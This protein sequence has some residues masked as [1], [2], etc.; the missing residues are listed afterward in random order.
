MLNRMFTQCKSSGSLRLP[1]CRIVWHI[2]QQLLTGSTNPCFRKQL[3]TN[4]ASDSQTSTCNI[5]SICLSQ[6]SLPLT[7]ALPPKL[8]NT[9]T[10]EHRAQGSFHFGWVCPLWRS[11]WAF[12]L[13]ADH[14]R[15]SSPVH[16]LMVHFN[17][18]GQTAL[19][20]LRPEL[21]Y[22]SMQC[23]GPF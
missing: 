19:R 14:G 8:L 5:I 21:C 6:L 15:S 18:R 12:K 7:P 1:N 9:F 16:L 20:S 11:T 10:D 4:I 23:R 13:T 2:S 17:Q 3:V 22:W